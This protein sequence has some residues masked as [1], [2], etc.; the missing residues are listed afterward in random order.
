MKSTRKHILAVCVLALGFA[1]PAIHAEDDTPPPP[2]KE[3]GPKGERGDMMKE[4]LGLSDEQDAQIKKIHAEAREQI[5]ALRQ[6]KLE[7]EERQAEVKKIREATREK[8]DAVLTAEQKAK[9]DKMRKNRG[10]PGPKGEKGAKDGTGPKGPPPVE[11][12]EM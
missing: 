5:K 2:R 9:L 11:E 12:P 1:V 10:G 7:P 3:A 8:V 4:K 6:K